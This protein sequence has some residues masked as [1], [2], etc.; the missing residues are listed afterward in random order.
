MKDFR[1]DVAERFDLPAECAGVLKATLMGGGRVLIENRKALLEYTTEMV[2]VTG[3]GVRLRVMGAALTL[4]A[5]DRDALL[6][7]GDITAL[8][9]G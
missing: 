9:L 4:R 1:E 3:G 6:I 5:M 8:E 7:S 2:E